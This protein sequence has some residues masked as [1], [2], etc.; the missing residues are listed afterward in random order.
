MYNADYLLDHK[1]E[2]ED[3]MLYLFNTFSD[4]VFDSPVL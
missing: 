3:I 4:V 2:L 1:N